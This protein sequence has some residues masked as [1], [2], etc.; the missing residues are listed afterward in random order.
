MR[1]ARKA[2]DACKQGGGCNACALLQPA[3]ISQE[4][5][6]LQRTAD[7][8]ETCREWSCL[9]QGG[10]LR[11]SD[12]P[13]RRAVKASATA[14]ANRLNGLRPCPV[15]GSAGIPRASQ[16]RC[17]GVYC[18]CMLQ[19]ASYCCCSP[20]QMKAQVGHSH[21]MS[22][23]AAAEPLAGRITAGLLVVRCAVCV[24]ALQRLRCEQ[25][26][27][28]EGVPTRRSP[29]V[30][31]WNSAAVA[32]ACTAILAGNAMPWKSQ[33]SH[34]Y[35]A[36]THSLRV[37]TLDTQRIRTRTAPADSI[38]GLLSMRPV[39]ACC[40]ALQ[41]EGGQKAEVPC[42]RSTPRSHSPQIC[43]RA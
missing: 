29:D 16:S 37:L 5:G 13:L 14:L 7:A 27:W 12:R 23:R 35:P 25:S 26:K 43:W 17:Q 6:E 11:Q 18:A 8:A 2:D 34:T 42:T 4:L 9:P 22:H 20:A 39:I 38:L 30:A 41:S 31:R 15:R 33:C 28:P 19:V 10:H 32:A 40:R 36:A 3:R 21:R 24:Q 1:P